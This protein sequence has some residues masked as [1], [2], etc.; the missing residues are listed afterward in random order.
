[1]RVVTWQG[2]NLPSGWPAVAK[3]SVKEWRT[4]RLG[5]PSALELVDGVDLGV[6]TGVEGSASGSRG[7]NAAG[8]PSEPSCMFSLEQKRQHG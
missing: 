5:V 1:M 4:L 6:A 7:G 8:V 3:D 2:E